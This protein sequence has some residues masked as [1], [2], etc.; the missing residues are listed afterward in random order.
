[1]AANVRSATE[2]LSKAVA[3][4]PAKVSRVAAK[5]PLLTLTRSVELPEIGHS[6]SMLFYDR[7][8]PKADR[9]RR[10]PDPWRSS[11]ERGKLDHQS[12]RKPSRMR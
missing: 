7:D 12:S 1:M 3:T 5:R 8:R 6:A 4:L 9:T 10:P 2:K 11:A